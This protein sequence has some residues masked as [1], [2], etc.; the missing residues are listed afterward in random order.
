MGYGGTWRAERDTRVA[1]LALG[2]A[3]GLS[4]VTAAPGSGAAVWLGGARRPIAGRVS[5]DS[6]GVE[7]G[8]EGGAE[9]IRPGD[10]AVFF[11]PIDADEQAGSSGVVPI[12]VEQA[13]AAAGTL[14]YELLVRVGRRVERD[15]TGASSGV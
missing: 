15:F 2:Y 14:H 9:A 5:M 8:P 11:G 12:P 4:W 7:I 10:E 6:V 1:T 13:A 3:D